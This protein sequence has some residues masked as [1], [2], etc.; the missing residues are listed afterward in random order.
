M[1]DSDN[2]TAMFLVDRWQRESLARGVRRRNL[3]YTEDTSVLMAVHLSQRTGQNSPLWEHSL[4]HITA[5]AWKKDA[6]AKEWLH[7][8]SSHWR[9][10]GGGPP[11]GWGGGGKELGRKGAEVHSLK[12]WSAYM[13]NKQI[14]LR[15]ICAEFSEFTPGCFMQRI[16]NNK[17]ESNQGRDP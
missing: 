13:L 10:S 8:V 1:N 9:T 11:E 14:Y 4:W 6:G 12:S 7:P 5:W 16:Q 17:A 2:H 15:N 3:L